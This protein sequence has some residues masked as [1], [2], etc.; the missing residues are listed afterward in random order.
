MLLDFFLQMFKR[1]P[2]LKGIDNYS[3]KE[4]VI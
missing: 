3:N 2:A 1:N 4:K